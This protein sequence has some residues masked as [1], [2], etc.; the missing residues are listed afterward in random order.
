MEDGNGRG[1][2]V[3]GR[4]SGRQGAGAVEMGIP[5]NKIKNQLLIQGVIF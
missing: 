1:W 2:A 4:S 3:G 5:I